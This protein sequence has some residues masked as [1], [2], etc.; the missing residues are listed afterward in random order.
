MD[1]DTDDLIEQLCARIGM[2]MEDLSTLALTIRE[3]KHDRRKA[4]L[5]QIET[6]THQI[7]ALIAAAKAV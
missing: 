5:V 3:R 7:R 1:Q 2:I 6:A 4:A